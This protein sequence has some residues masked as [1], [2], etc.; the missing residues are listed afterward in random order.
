MSTTP[1]L[2]PPTPLLLLLKS[3]KRSSNRRCRIKAPARF[4]RKKAPFL[5]KL[6]ELLGSIAGMPDAIGLTIWKERLQ[7]IVDGFD[8]I[9]EYM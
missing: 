2:S 7:K 3:D 1:R 9:V 5:I 6:D 4:T 8:E